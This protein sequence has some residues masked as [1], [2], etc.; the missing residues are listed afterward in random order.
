MHRKITR[1]FRKDYPAS[2]PSR[3]HCYL[4]ALCTTAGLGGADYAAAARR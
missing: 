3:G 4:L 2:A 1:W